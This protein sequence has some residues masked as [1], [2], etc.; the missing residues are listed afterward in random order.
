MQIHEIHDLSNKHVTELLITSLS[1]ISDTR[2]IKNYHPDYNND[3]GNIFYILQNGRYNL[4]KGKYYV[5]ENNGE[6][7]CSAGWN[8]YEPDIAL[9]LTRMYIAPKH[10]VNYYV[11]TNIL[12]KILEEVTDYKHV[13]ATVN[14][15]NKAL[16]EWFV[17]DKLGK[18]TALFN[19]W[20][21]IYKN[22]KPVGKK[23]IYY[24]DQYV[25]ELDRTINDQTTKN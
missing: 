21:D 3:T 19:N 14:A 13:W 7:I 23:N 22:F 25:I 20:P 4:G 12:P 8:E 17:R 9:I 11:A 10:R 6:Y 16:Y 1:G 24:T 2:I 5:L 18:R 15:Y